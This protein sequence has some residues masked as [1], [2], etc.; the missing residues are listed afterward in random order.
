MRGDVNL[1]DL[2]ALRMGVPEFLDDLP[3]GGRRMVQRASGYVATYVAGVRVFEN[4]EDTGAR[5]GRTVRRRQTARPSADGQSLSLQPDICS[6][7]D[8]AV[9]AQSVLP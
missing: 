9:A 2:A 7:H 3:A 4:G 6:A 5:P 8:K 1:I